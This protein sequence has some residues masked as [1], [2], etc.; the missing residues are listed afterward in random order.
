VWDF[1]RELRE[2]RRREYWDWFW[3]QQ[4]D[5]DLDPG[6]PASLHIGCGSIL[7][8]VGFAFLV[9][10]GGG[11]VGFHEFWAFPALFVGMIGAAAIAQW[12]RRRGDSPR[13][14]G[15]RIRHPIRF[16]VLMGAI[17]WAGLGLWFAISEGDLPL[18]RAAATFGGIGAVLGLIVGS[19]VRAG[20]AIRRRR[21]T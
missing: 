4:R 16:H 19:L 1:D 13:R 9:W 3:K 6:R 17:G 8:G 15:P 14:S 10:F 18:A 5:A 20:R 12:V 2:Q 7:A 21:T 11:F